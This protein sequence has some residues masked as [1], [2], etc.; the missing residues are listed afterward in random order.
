MASTE[1]VWIADGSARV[2]P[3]E[4]ASVSAAYR[5]GMKR[6][7]VEVANISRTGAKIL[8]LD[9]LKAGSTFWIKLPNLEPLEMSVVWTK[10][11]EAGCR[12]MKPLHPAIFQVVAQAVRR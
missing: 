7:S 4:P 9:P 8:T 6:S 2:E 5:S 10:G 1:Q 3:R 12:F 11:F